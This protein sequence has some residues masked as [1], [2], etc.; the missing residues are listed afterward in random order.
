MI[1]FT[2]LLCM[3]NKQK[4][5]KTYI[6]TYIQYIINHAVYDPIFI[7]Y[8]VSTLVSAHLRYRDCLGFRQRIQYKAPA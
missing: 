4:P 3:K 2:L 1:A 8:A 6:Q 7:Q 5:T